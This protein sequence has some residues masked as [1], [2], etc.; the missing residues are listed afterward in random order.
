[1]AGIKAFGAPLR[2]VDAADFTRPDIVFQIGVAPRRIDLLTSISGV[3][4]DEAWAERETI[5][6]EGLRIHVLS[7][8]AHLI[9]NKRAAARPK[10]LSDLAWLEAKQQ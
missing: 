3:G 4:F 2:R 9:A 7:R 5:D 10:D 8:L 1:M 6:V